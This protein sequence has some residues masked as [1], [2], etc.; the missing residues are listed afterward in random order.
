[1]DFTSKRDSDLPQTHE[2]IELVYRNGSVR[3]FNSLKYANSAALLD[4]ISV[5]LILNDDP[6]TIRKLMQIPNFGSKTLLELKSLALEAGK[7]G[8]TIDST[9]PLESELKSNPQTDKSHLLNEFISSDRAPNLPVPISYIQI[10]TRFLSHDEQ[11][12][13]KKIESTFGKID[14]RSFLSIDKNML[15]DING[16]GKTYLSNF[17][18]IQK[19]VLQEFFEVI[20]GAKHFDSSLKKLFLAS[21]DGKYNLKEIDQI[22]LDDVE[23]YLFALNDQDRELAMS[24]WGFHCKGMTL[25]ELG[26][27]FNVTRERIRQK[28]SFLNERLLLNIRLPPNA[29]RENLLSQSYL[30][31]NEELYNLSSCFEAEKDFLGFL[32]MLSGS[33]KGSIYEIVHPN[34]SNKVIETYFSE[35]SAPVAYEVLIQELESN[36]GYQKISIIN[37]IRNWSKDSILKIVNNKVSPINLGKIEATAHILS[38]HPLGLPWKDIAALVNKSGC[39]ST[40]IDEDRSI[41]SYLGNSEYLY[42]CGRGSYRHLKFL[43]MSQINVEALM[44][45]LLY[46]FVTKDVDSINLNDF[47]FNAKPSVKKID[48]FTLRQIVRS[49]CDVFGFYFNGKSGVDA[50]GITPDFNRVTQENVILD[51]MSKAKGAMTIIEIA[52]RLRSNSVGHAR[53]YLERLMEQGKIVRIDNMMYALPSRAFED[54]DTEKILFLMRDILNDAM[55]I[56]EA[57][58]FRVSINEKLNLSYTKYFYAALASINLHKYG[59]KKCHNLFSVKQIPYSS[60][61]NAISLLCDINASNA[62]NMDKLR[63]EIVITDYFANSILNNWKASHK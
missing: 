40:H 52:E 5:K 34:I 4:G 59:W 51:F 54:I 24:R 61:T 17:E 33:E 31:F 13:L 35:N 23:D 2:L 46:F 12:T 48:Y 43:D 30:D 14:L 49:S 62:Q 37:A 16:F 18:N 55:K 15:K 22:L 41:Q 44:D 27:Q 53:F 6:S 28:I 25:N 38:N 42:L 11:K 29:L 10:N 36:Y 20:D 21:H 57:D 47:Y 39:C 19:D 63:E 9:N 60:I 7:F 56:V 50:L 26:K 8:I 45:E 32:E 3:L 1:M 58:T